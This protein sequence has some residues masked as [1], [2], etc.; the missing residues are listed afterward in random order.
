[1]LAWFRPEVVVG[2]VGEREVWS[3]VELVVTRSI[4]V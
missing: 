2:I 4:D 1:M 3:G